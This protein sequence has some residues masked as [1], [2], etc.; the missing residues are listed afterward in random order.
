MK[1]SLLALMCSLLTAHFC[2]AQTRPKASRPKTAE[3]NALSLPFEDARRMTVLVQV[4][5]E[6]PSRGSAVW[7]GKTGYL[8]TCYH[9]VQD[10]M[11][12]PLFVGTPHDPVAVSNGG[13]NIG[14]S[15]LVDVIDVTVKAFDPV[16]DIAILLAS[17]P[18][19]HVP[20]PAVVVLGGPPVAEEKLWI[21]K[22][23]VL[24]TEFPKAGQTLL[25]AG[26]PLNERTLILQLGVATGL[27]LFMRPPFPKDAPAANALRIVLS[28]VSNT[29]NS[30][31][32]VFDQGG[33]VVGLLLGNLSAP[34]K[35]VD[36]KQ[37]LACI[38]AKLDPNGNPLKDAQGNAI[39]EPTPCLQNSGI[40]IAIPAKFITELAK[41]NNIDLQ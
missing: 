21:S 14:V 20:E 41:K 26:Y 29:G 34:M 5:G 4:K 39:P 33:R 15:G 18:P 9:V 7:V 1:A 30:G 19:G 40:S 23:A 17:E 25:L 6:E 38:R 27:E 11:Q 35:D 36:N 37:N 10:A 12:K 28:L 3:Q 13:V 2:S 24:A 16:T 8:A 31:G 32:P 22:G